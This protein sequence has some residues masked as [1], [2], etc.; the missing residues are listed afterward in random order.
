MQRII[1]YV[2]RGLTKCFLFMALSIGTPAVNAMRFLD[3][4]EAIVI[5]IDTSRRSRNRG[6]IRAF[7]HVPE[8]KFSAYV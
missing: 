5:V 6:I 2:S 3:E 8:Y 7:G 4:R 1:V